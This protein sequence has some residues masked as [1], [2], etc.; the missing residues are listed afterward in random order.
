MELTSPEFADQARIP[1]RFTCEGENASPPLDWSDVPDG[2]AD[3]ALTC[4]DPDAPGSTFVHWVLWGLHPTISGLRANAVPPG[5][6]AGRNG[7]GRV[8]YDGPCPPPGHGTHHYYFR[9]WALD[10]PIDLP[11]GAS[12]DELHQAARSRLLDEA[13]LVGT[14]QR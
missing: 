2:A 8:G 5:V 11:E 13:T 3:L 7:F 10:A 14:Y 4:E 6:H 1:R 9:L 12:I